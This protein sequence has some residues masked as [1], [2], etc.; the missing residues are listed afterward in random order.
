MQRQ[1]DPFNVIALTETEQGYSTGSPAQRLNA[2]DRF[3][4]GKVRSYDRR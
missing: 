2:F 3:S 4:L 1:S